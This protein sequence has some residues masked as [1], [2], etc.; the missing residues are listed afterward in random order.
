MKF[1]DFRNPPNLLRP[2][3]FWAINDR[4][5]PQE[6]E[7]QFRDMRDKGLGG[8][9]FHSRAGLITD[10]LGQEWFDSMEAAL[11]AAEDTDGYL[12]LYDEDLWPSGC[13]GGQVAALGDEYRQTFLESILLP[14]GKELD[15][16]A[17]S[18]ILRVYQLTKRVGLKLE[19]SQDMGPIDPAKVSGDRLV[20]RRRLDPKNPWWS[21]ESYTN[22]LNPDV[23]AKFMEF[24]HEVYRKHLGKHFGKRIPG[25]FT[26][27]PQLTQ[28]G[29]PWYA[30]L[31]EIYEKRFGR[32][33]WNDFPLV[34]FDGPNQR[35]VRLSMHRLLLDQFVSAYSRPLFEWC[36]KNNLAHTGHYNA[37]E[38]LLSQI[39]NHG[40]GIMAHYRCQQIPGVDHLCRVTDQ[41][42]LTLKQVSSS[43]RQL[44]APYALNEIFGVS[45][46]TN[47]FEDF[48]W[49]ADYSMVQGAV[50]LC[51]HLTWY[52]MRGKRKRDY[53]PNWNYQQS[54][55]Q[56]LRPLNDYFA[57]LATALSAGKSGAQILI[58]HPIE[59]AMASI[60]RGI[61]TSFCYGI[62]QN[63]QDADRVNEINRMLVRVMTAVQ[64]AGLD[65]DLGDEGYLADLGKIERNQFAVGG[66]KYRF[67]IVP[68]AK[69]WRRSTFRL[70]EQFAGN[71]GRILFA[72]ELPQELDCMEA[73][74]DW[75]RLFACKTVATIPCGSKELLE[76]I[77]TALDWPYALTLTD[78][79]P[80]CGVKVHDRVD[81]GQHRF[82]IVNTDRQAGRSLRIAFPKSSILPL[83]QWDALTGEEKPVSLRKEGTALVCE[84]ELPPAGSILLTGGKGVSAR[85]LQKRADAVRK[86]HALP[87]SWKFS[88][89]EPNVL[90]LDR[91]SYSVDGGNTWSKEDLDHRIRGEIAAHFGTRESLSWQPWVAVRKKLFDG[92]CGEITLRY[93]F[94]SALEKI[95]N[96]SVVIEDLA[97]GSLTVNGHSVQTKDCAWHWD[98]GFGKIDMGSLIRQGEN[99]IL[100]KLQYD[101]LSE[102]EPA[103]VVGD[104]GVRLADGRTGELCKEPSSLQTGAWKDQP[105][106]FYSGSMRYQA[107][108]KRPISGPRSTEGSRFFLRLRNPSCILAKVSINGKLLDPMLWRPWEIEITDALKAGTNTI[109]I[110]L[111]SSRQNTHGPLH[112]TEG[113]SYN[114]FGPEAFEDER[115][116]RESFSLYGYGLL[117]KAE[118]VELE[119]R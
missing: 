84:F 80:A 119:S 104:F 32:S 17:E 42:F 40:G 112:V 69:T 57:R 50:F 63:T 118:I 21:A 13:A 79:T 70:L 71:G 31:P 37:E 97:K 41:L 6:T 39:L 35:I 111:V 19:C 55:W 20:I 46:H 90:I 62:A 15:S 81:G 106:P 86:V 14:A 95:H 25:I 2:T 44:N 83:A 75:N 47:T 105:Y 24:T 48:R 94:R 65:F 101:F 107:A 96:A 18:E 38:S 85:R 92:K 12:W 51:P 53:P 36:K 3:P 22:L 115:I 58:L 76:Y 116:L 77:S 26:D 11:K 61:N 64:D 89:S 56:D 45:H 82:F 8:G 110:D 117:G 93:R 49:L 109:E 59:E 43:V 5:T 68:P 54:Y 103:Y 60:R 113:D 88:R 67:L 9:F 10:Y 52:S 4:I 16:P 102:V 66:G 7:R 91:L 28:Q 72:G 100:F 87:E 78:G 74:T 29:F 1:A 33:F 108:W 98:R 73:Q 23:T 114:W 30:R 99:E 27:E 34:V